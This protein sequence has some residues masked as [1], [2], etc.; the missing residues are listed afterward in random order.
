ML[1]SKI[2]ASS[3]I[4]LFAAAPLFPTPCAE[5]GASA[6][7]LSTPSPPKVTCRGP[8]TAVTA[9]FRTCTAEWARISSALLPL[10]VD[11][12]EDVS[13]VGLEAIPP[14]VCL[15]VPIHR[16]QV[17]ELPQHGEVAVH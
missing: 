10:D 8:I 3:A 9:P 6:R 17:G 15:H 16:R 13:E 4:F 12:L 7:N 14:L 11:D 1:N 2:S 5:T